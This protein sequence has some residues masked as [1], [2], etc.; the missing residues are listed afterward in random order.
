MPISPERLDR[1]SRLIAQNDRK[2]I[3]FQIGTVRKMWERGNLEKFRLKL[4]IRDYCWIYTDTIFPA[5]GMDGK[6]K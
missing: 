3:S 5:P 2:R 4:K 1:F 6:G